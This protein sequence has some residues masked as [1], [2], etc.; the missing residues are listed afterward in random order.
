MKGKN[1]KI[2]V[3]KRTITKK[4]EYERRGN[5][6]RGNNKRIN[7]RRRSRTNSKRKTRI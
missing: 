2:S 3:R 1:E 5:K 7:K 6:I 4:M